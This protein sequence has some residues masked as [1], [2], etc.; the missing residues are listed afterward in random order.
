MARIALAVGAAALGAVVGVMTG[1][2]GMFPIG[3]WTADILAGASA[4]F[5]VGAVREEDFDFFRGQRLLSEGE[6][7]Q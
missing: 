4:G 1:G 6:K 3:A 5:S 2:L 7:R